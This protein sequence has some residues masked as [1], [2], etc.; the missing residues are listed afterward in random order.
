MDEKTQ[1][2]S[3]EGID[4]CD[5]VTLIIKKTICPANDY[6]L[7]VCNDPNL[8]KYLEDRSLTDSNAQDNWIDQPMG[9]SNK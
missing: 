6:K 4:K 3:R 2:Q 9:M 1:Q 5:N 8:D 7:K